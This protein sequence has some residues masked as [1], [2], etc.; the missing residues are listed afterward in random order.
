MIFDCPDFQRS[1]ARTGTWVP[2]DSPFNANS[3]NPPEQQPEVQTS[4]RRSAALTT[5]ALPF[6]RK[7][8]L[9]TE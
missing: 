4:S 5:N 6:I 1:S 2:R 3:F 8:K 7:F 9:L